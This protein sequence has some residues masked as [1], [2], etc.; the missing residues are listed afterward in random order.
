M[1]AGTNAF[2]RVSD[3]PWKIGHSKI[4][5]S[6]VATGHCEPSFAKPKTAKYAC[7]R[8]GIYGVPR[9]HDNDSAVTYCGQMATTATTTKLLSV[10]LGE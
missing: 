2:R 8:M 3:S 10:F 1:F 5:S 7:L 9:I 4:T 6:S